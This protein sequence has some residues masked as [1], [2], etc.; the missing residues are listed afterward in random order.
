[1]TN[2]SSAGSPPAN[3]D[4]LQAVVD[5]EKPWLL[6]AGR[7][8]MSAIFII[9]GARKIPEFGTF[10]AYMVAYG[11]PLPMLLLPLAI[12]LEIGAGVM[13]LTGVRAREASAALFAYTVLL[14]FIFHSF[15]RYSD[16]QFQSQL[17]LFLFHLSTLG[18]LAYLVA[19]GTGRFRLGSRDR[20]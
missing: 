11:V 1:M 20:D 6:L 3:V 10:S 9:A 5:K 7:I 15:W 13:I 2:A 16:A 8:L 18:G 17:N 12:V 14:T 19:C 4:M